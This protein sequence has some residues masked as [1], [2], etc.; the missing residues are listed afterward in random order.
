VQAASLS[1]GAFEAD[2]GGFVLEDARAPQ[3]RRI[4]EALELRHGVGGPHGGAI[5]LPHRAG[6]MA[7]VPADMKRVRETPRPAQIAQQNRAARSGETFHFR[8]Q[9]FGLRKV[10]QHRVAHHEI[11]T[12]IGEWKLVAIRDLK[13]DAPGKGGASGIEIRAGLR[14]HV[15][16]TVDARKFPAREAACELDDYLPRASADIEGAAAFA[17]IKEAEGVFDERFVDSV[18]MGL[19]RRPRIGRHLVRIVHDFGFGNA[20]Q[21]EETH[22]ESVIKGRE[23]MLVGRARKKLPAR[24]ETEPEIS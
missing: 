6:I 10:M 1:D 18:E 5:E 12:S 22:R 8:K 16:R 20:P 24:R 4:E 19:R 11:E 3:W 9:L 7:A 15:R 23:G 21:N 14:D 2:V 17:S 13:L